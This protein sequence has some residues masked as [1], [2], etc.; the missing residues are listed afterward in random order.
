MDL[1]AYAQID[2][3]EAIM[4]ANGIEI[5]RLRGL[6]LME[7]E[8]PV[9]DE[10]LRKLAVEEGLY[11]CMGL[12]RSGFDFNSYCSTYSDYTDWLC[13]RFIEID[14]QY[15]EDGTYS[16][17]KPVAIKWDKVHGK[18]RK[19]FKYVIKKA[20]KE[21]FEQ[22]K[23]WN[24]YAGMKNVLYIHCRLGAGNWSSYNVHEIIESK[25]WFLDDVEDYFDSTYL[26]VYAKIDPE[27]SIR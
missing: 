12:C 20:K 19:A 24:K 26:D 4:K 8:E 3:L 21:V 11:R 25:P 23:V 9:S 6:R 17:K 14:E 5:P 2:D 27:V 10:E 1:G 7:N 13:E 15:N 22:F 16:F 18:K